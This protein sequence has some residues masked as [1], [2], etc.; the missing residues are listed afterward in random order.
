M[1]GCVL[2]SDKV[3]IARPSVCDGSET[4]LVSE[5]YKH[6]WSELCAYL[7][8]RYGSGPPEP[9]DVAQQAFTQFVALEDRARIKNPRAYIY[10]AARNYVVDQHRANQR[11][12]AYQPQFEYC[13]N[14][15]GVDELSPEKV[16]SEKQRFEIF[17]QALDKM[18]A[19]RRRMI[20]LQRFEGLTCEEIGKR[21]GMQGATVQKQIRRAL[22]DCSIAIEKAAGDVRC[23]K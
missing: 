10:A 3:N 23:T 5:L 13:E 19:Q 22:I 16:L 14:L 8:A 15:D 11:K 12:S 6:Y 21:F 2:P 17:T 1:L 4:P 9:A 18:P 20:L 7:T